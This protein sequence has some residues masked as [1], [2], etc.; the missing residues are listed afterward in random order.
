M[1]KISCVTVLAASAFFNFGVQANTIQQS[2][3]G[4]TGLF[5]TETF[6]AGTPATLAGNQFTGLS[7]GSDLYVDANYSGA[8]PNMNGN[9]IANFLNNCNCVTPT[10]I[11]FDSA[12]TGAAFNFVSNTGTSTF[13][14]F[15]GSTQ[16]EQFSAP[17]GYGGE[18]YGFT[19]ILF[20]SIR[21]DSGG[22]NNA[23]ILD[24]LQVSAVPEPETYAMLLVGLGLV[25][26]TL[27]NKKV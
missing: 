11:S 8:F 7:F 5:T 2:T 24:N 15:L 26:F 17:T 13:T 10:F 12:V 9:V 20:D 22:G 21:V 27:R 14:A 25:G 3:S 6:D 4:L 16:I 19:N 23:Y 18:F 1:K